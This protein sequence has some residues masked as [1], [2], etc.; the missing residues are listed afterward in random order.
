MIQSSLITQNYS[1][2]Y[3]E[4]P[5]IL[6]KLIDSL[7]WLHDLDYSELSMFTE[8]II[9][10]EGLRPIMLLL[11]FFTFFGGKKLKICAFYINFELGEGVCDGLACD[12]ICH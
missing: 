1:F 11:M 7:K 8:I 10:I 2:D 4:L 12:K 9:R 3:S 6:K 5:I